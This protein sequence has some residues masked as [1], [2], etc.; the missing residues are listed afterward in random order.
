MNLMQDA[1]KSSRR[2]S[3]LTVSARLKVGIS[4]P[5]KSPLALKDLSMQGTLFLSKYPNLF[6]L[7]LLIRDSRR[8]L[9][10][11]ETSLTTD[12]RN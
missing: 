7:V 12:Q 6:V 4:Q 11:M 10:I 1:T 5:L 9:I 8:I 3:M 2:E